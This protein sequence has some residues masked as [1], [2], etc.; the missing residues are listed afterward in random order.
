M[1]NSL[2]TG[3]FSNDLRC[4]HHPGNCQFDLM[5]WAPLSGRRWG[6]VLLLV[7]LLLLLFSVVFFCWF[8]RFDV[9]LNKP[10]P[11]SW[12]NGGAVQVPQSSA[13]LSV[14][15]MLAG[16]GVLS[17]LSLWTFLFGLRASIF[18][19][20]FLLITQFSYA[21]TRHCLLH[22]C[23]EYGDRYPYR[24]RRQSPWETAGGNQQFPLLW[25][26]EGRD[27]AASVSA[28]R[29]GSPR[30]RRPKSRPMVRR[31]SGY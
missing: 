9:K 17:Q 2:K 8:W 18:I 23:F 10:I 14:C 4:F 7:V 20:V 15:L 19:S 31:R 3:I 12:T 21:G 30:F 28:A 1:V 26:L 25:V 6:I 29:H 16:V 22:W 24:W 27:D 11:V 13:L 5:S